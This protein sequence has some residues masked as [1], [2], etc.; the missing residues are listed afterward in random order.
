M[1]IIGRSTLVFTQK[2]FTE[3]TREFAYYFLK[4]LDLAHFNSGS[5]QPSLNRNY[6]HPLHV[7]LPGRTE[8]DAIVDLLGA[9]DDK[10]ELNRRMNETLEAMARAIFRDWFVDFGPARAKQEGREPY[11][12]PEIWS[13]FPDRLDVD[14]NPEGWVE[15]RLGDV[16]SRVAI[17]PFGSDITTDNFVEEGVPVIRGGNLKEG[18]VDEGF[19]YLTE[20][21]ADQLKN[22]N[23][24]PDDIILTH[25]GTLGQVG[26]IP[27]K[28]F[29][30]RY[31]ISQS[32]MLLTVDR[33]LSTPRFVFEF[34]R[35]PY[36]NDQLLANTS[37]TGVP[38]IA[39][40]TTSLK[41]LLL[42]LPPMNVLRAFEE[43]LAPLVDR[44]HAGSVESRVLANLRD[45]LLPKLMSGE[46]RLKNV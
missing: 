24:F 12:V 40:P 10:I 23:A 14:G 3:T 28:P 34:L 22:A 11:L 35:S 46:V 20:T 32:Q 19:V 33:E 37:Q 2:I 41:S 16:C 25:R 31:V 18:F 43:I 36:G 7:R 29:F 8:Q 39:R 5:A 27:K 9:L 17:G 6:I 44:M 1:L 13:L 30:P 21:K 15:K 45:L 38:A 42:T 4:T 26:I